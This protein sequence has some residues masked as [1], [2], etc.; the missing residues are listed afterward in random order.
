MIF[1]GVGLLFSLAE[2]CKNR[3]QSRNKGVGEPTASENEF[4]L[5]ARLKRPP[6]KNCQFLVVSMFDV[7]IPVFA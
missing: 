3:Q 2:K 4:S 5:V 1:Y 6:A 7:A